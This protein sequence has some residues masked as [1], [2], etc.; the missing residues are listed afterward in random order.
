[1][2]WAIIQYENNF[3]FLEFQILS[4]PSHQFCGIFIKNLRIIGC[5]QALE[6]HLTSKCNGDYHGYRS[7]RMNI[8]RCIESSFFDP[9]I[10][11]ILEADLE[12]K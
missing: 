7:S 6:E 9:E 11:T 4:E 2:N 1:M 10:V 12:D 3:F 5:F 8:K